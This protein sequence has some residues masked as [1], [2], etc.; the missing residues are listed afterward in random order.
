MIVNDDIL[1]E[2]GL[3]A[4]KTWEDLADPKYKGEVIMSDPA[5]SGT[6]YAIVS[7]LIQALGEEKAWDYF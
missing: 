1:K 4:P 2:K 6:N 7:G 5:I 3:E